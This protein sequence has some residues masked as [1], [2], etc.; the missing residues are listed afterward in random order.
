MSNTVLK[1]LVW[2]ALPLGLAV[3]CAS[4]H[5]A[6]EASEASYDQTA[7]VL[8]PTS[9]EPESKIYVSS[10]SD[11]SA[12]PQ[13]TSPQ[14]WAIAEA[15]QQKL[16]SD[17]SLAPLGSTLIAQVSTDGTVTLKGNVSSESEQ[18]RVRESISTVPGVRNVNT[19]QL[20]VGRY[21]GPSNLNM[22]QL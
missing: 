9:A 1:N 3:G 11:M 20:V 14:T 19:Q 4:N 22:N 12:A 17:P 15:I 8:T 6:T 13:G 21:N 18:D 7:A 2:I 10:S 16:L 5:P